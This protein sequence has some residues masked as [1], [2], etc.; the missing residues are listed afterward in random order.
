MTVTS[1]DPGSSMPGREAPN[2]PAGLCLDIDISETCLGEGDW[3]PVIKRA[4]SA[5]LR[6][7]LSGPLPG[8]ELYVALVPNEQSQQLNAQYRDKDYATNVL[9]FPATEPE[10]LTDALKASAR[11]GPPLMLGDLIIAGKVVADEAAAQQKSTTAHLSHLTVH[12]VLH[13][14]GYDHMEDNEA[15]EMEA[16]EREILKSLGFNDPYEAIEE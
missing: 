2:A 7:G 13:L 1:D 11:G 15:L 14:L 5:A 9:S 12:G 6:R 10:E 3:T 16:L 4:V 8:A